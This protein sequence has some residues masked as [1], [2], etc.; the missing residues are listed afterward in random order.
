MPFNGTY[1]V[2]LRVYTN[3]QVIRRKINLALTKTVAGVEFVKTEAWKQK[4]N[5]DSTVD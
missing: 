2:E 4:I 3:Y 1:V 5:E